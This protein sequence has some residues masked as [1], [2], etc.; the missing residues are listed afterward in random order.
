MI[1]KANAVKSKRA[2]CRA[3]DYIL[4]EGKAAVKA[5][6]N[7]FGTEDF[8]LQ[9]E[10]ISKLW[11]KTSGRLGY[12]FIFSFDPKDDVT[13]ALALRVVNKIIHEMFPNHQAILA[14]HNDTDHIHI[15]AVMGAID[16][17]SGRKV[18]LRNQSYAKL[19]DKANEICVE[20]GLSPF[21]WREAVRRKR[22]EE[23][24]GEYPEQ[25]CFAE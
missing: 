13:N 19:K 9:I 21:D 12:H 5:V 17:L 4:S 18:N 3:I 8:A 7:L 24:L 1:V 15:H 16:P 22:Q 11:G 25:Y 2:L 10:E 14:V 20:F 6:R 23:R